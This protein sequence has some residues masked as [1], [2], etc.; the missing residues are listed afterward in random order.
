MAKRFGRNQKRK[1]RESIK[2]NKAESEYYQRQVVKLDNEMAHT[3]QSFHKLIAMIERINPNSICLPVKEIQGDPK[4]DYFYLAARGRF[5]LMAVPVEYDQ[6]SLC[7]E[8]AI[9]KVKLQRFCAGVDIDHAKMGLCCHARVVGN[10]ASAYYITSGSL[11]MFGVK[12][13]EISEALALDLQRQNI[14]TE[15]RERMYG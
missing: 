9:D 2:T 1:M 13:E 15:P 8:I 3:R 7:E 10:G 4:M 14:E 6:R 5:E 12:V 11:R